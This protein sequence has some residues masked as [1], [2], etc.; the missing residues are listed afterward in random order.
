MAWVTCLG[1]AKGGP[2]EA[3]VGWPRVFV[4]LCVSLYLC[5]FECVCMCLFVCFFAYVVFS[6]SEFVIVLE[7]SLIICL[8]ICFA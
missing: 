2:G 5:F 6:A 8:C 3:R 4:F 7:T 1:D